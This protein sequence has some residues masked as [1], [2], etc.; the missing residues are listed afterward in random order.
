MRCLIDARV[1][2]DPNPGGVTRVANALIEKIIEL[3]QNDSFTLVTTGFKQPA[4]HATRYSASWRTTPL[5]HFSHLYL[6][7]KLLALTTFAGLMSLDRLAKNH[8]TLF[9]PNLEMVGV[10]KIPYALLVHDLSFLIEPKWFSL[11]S[12][13]WHIMT[14]AKTLIK[15]ADALFTVS[16]HTKQDLINYLAVD[17]KKI[18]VL[19]LGNTEIVDTDTPLPPELQNTRYFLALGTSDP[20]KNLTCITTAFQQLLKNADFSD[21][22]LALIGTPSPHSRYPIPDTRY[23]F[24]PRPSDALLST[25]MKNASA[26]LYPSWYEGYGLPLHEA[27]AHGTPII[28]STSG[29]LPETAP[30]GTHFVPPFKP[31]LWTQAMQS[32]LE[33][34]KHPNLA[35]PHQTWDEAAGII[36]NTLQSLIT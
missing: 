26:L 13:L 32:V 15:N 16:H 14:R 29:A 7:N 28:A 19:P 33:N 36:K 24:L 22:K 25:L 8:D 2:T 34:P 35:P 27:A 1:L 31:H 9:L 21:I 30:P 6:P 20:R 10:P 11:K 12:R 17:E 23:Y 4:L 3:N 18:H 5:L